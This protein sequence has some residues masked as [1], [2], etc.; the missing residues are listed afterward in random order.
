MKS[1]RI[2]FCLLLFF[3][4][5]LV[6]AQLTSIGSWRDHLPYHNATFVIEVENNIYCVTE[7]GLFYFNK[8]DQTINR[9]SKV[10]GLSDTEVTKVAYQSQSKTLLIAYKNCNIDLIKDGQ[11]INI[12]DI[13]QKP[14]LG[15]KTINNIL[16]I[17]KIAYLSC[18]FGLVVLDTEAEEI[19]DTYK[20]GEGGNFVKINDTSLDGDSLFVATS[21]GIY[22]ANIKEV[23]LSDFHNWRKHSAFEIGLNANSKFENIAYFDGNI[24]ATTTNDFNK[25]VVIFYKNNLWRKLDFRVRQVANIHHEPQSK[26]LQ[27]LSVSYNNLIIVYEDEI[28][29]IKKSGGMQQI[30]QNISKARDA[31]YDKDGNVWVADFDKDLLMYNNASF[32]QQIDPNGPRTAN[33]FKLIQNNDDLCV[34]PGGYYASMAP[35]W[36]SDGVFFYRENSTWD[37]NS[38]SELGN[39]FDIVT[40]VFNPNNRNEVYLGSWNGGVIKLDNNNFVEKYNYQ[41]TNGA[42]DTISFSNANG[43]IRV[44]DLKFD[45][46]GNMWGLNSLVQNSLFVKTKSN[47]WYSFNVKGV[48]G[49][50][51]EFKDLVIDNYG[52]KWGIIKNAGLFV[53]DDNETIDNQNDDEIQLINKNIGSGNLPSLE[54]YSLAVDL[55]GEIWVGTDKGIAVFYSAELVFSGEN[56]DAQQILI[57]QGEYGQYLLDTETINCIEID[58]NNRKWIGTNG[59]GVFLLSDD[60]SNEIH[61]FTTENSPLFSDNIIDIAINEISG[62]VFIGT[63]KGIISYRS[64]AT[65]GFDAHKNV[66]V[67]PNPV[68]ENYNGKIAIR[69]LVNNANVKITDINGNLVFESFANGSQAI[70]DG[71]NQSGNR[72]STGV[73]LVFSSNIDGEE[74]MVSKILFIH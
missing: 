22:S 47:N 52:Q 10:N 38:V 42:L 74:T 59:A 28:K 5:F 4:P 51:S 68:K 18:P 66:L 61:H 8:A 58:G 36:N 15:E 32:V 55:E 71:K 39:T 21:S 56:F 44:S 67:F 14:I 11:I 24:Y 29:I 33:N 1:I 20:I 49:S 63:E 12:S 73:Y 46:N 41:N 37:Y 35:M 27:S 40:A 6:K 13:K 9:I 48:D 50:S 53:Y 45:K 69:G 3:S 62:E 7:S 31:I 34:V 17:D 60:G 72:A 25:D 30:T 23:N 64:D 54:V 43:R 70:W 2:Y 57:Q 26:K 19:L 65:K 16:F